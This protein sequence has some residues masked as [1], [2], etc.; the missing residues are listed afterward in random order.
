MSEQNSDHHDADADSTTASPAV[1]LAG[2][3]VRGSKGWA[4]RDVDLQADWGDVVAITGTSGSGRSALLLTI[5]GRMRPSTGNIEVVGVDLAAGGNRGPGLREVRRQAA[6]ARLAD[7]IGLDT[8]LTV[9]E[10]TE[11]AADWARCHRPEVRDRLG[12]W[13]AH[14]GLRLDPRA[15]VGELPA[16]EATVLHLLLAAVTE[17]EVILLDDADMNLT[18]AERE[19]FWR[20]AGDVAG[21][22][23]VVIATAT[24]APP[25][26]VHLELPHDEPTSEENGP[27]L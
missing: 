12:R 9:R 7:H 20:I 26:Q 10:N 6:V 16:L 1:V 14:T 21:Q 23:R 3:G 2:L 11:D 22:D 15:T 4:F 8:D 27:Q 19:I 17:A 5:A 13:R 18:P 25:T 24:E